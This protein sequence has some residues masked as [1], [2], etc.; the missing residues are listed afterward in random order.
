MS[1]EACPSPCFHHWCFH[2]APTFFRFSMCEIQ[3]SAWANAPVGSAS[4]FSKRQNLCPAEN[5]GVS[6]PWFV[7]TSSGLSNSG[8]RAEL[9]FVTSS[10]KCYNLLWWCFFIPGWK[11]QHKNCGKALKIEVWNR[12]TSIFYKWKYLLDRQN[13]TIVT[14]K[15]LVYWDKLQLQSMTVRS[16]YE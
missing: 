7:S 11:M 9:Y 2:K 12:S 13:F 3:P 14:L 10:S 16:F 1:P 5:P 8:F 6:T 4:E 15:I